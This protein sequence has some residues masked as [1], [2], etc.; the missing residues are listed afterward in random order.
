VNA[1]EIRRALACGQPQCKCARGMVHCPAHNDEKPSLAVSDKDGKVLIRCWAK[2]SQDAVI[3]ALQERG[4]WNQ[5]RPKTGRRKVRKA[6]WHV[7]GYVHEKTEYSDGSKDFKWKREDGTYGLNG[8]SLSS[9]PLYGADKLDGLTSDATIVVT[10]GEK[11]ADSLIK[12]EIP[13][14]GT[15]TGANET[16]C[17][18]SLK[19]LASYDVI[20][21]PDA[22]Q[23]G[24]DHM[25]RIAARLRESGHDNIRVIEWE[26][27][28]AKADAADFPGDNAAVRDL[29]NRARLY[30]PTPS[31]QLADLL[32][33]VRC[34]VRRYVAINDA[35]ADAIALWIAHTHAVDGAEAT[36]YIEITSA[37]KRSGKTR[38]LEVL[39]Q[40]AKDSWFTGRVSAAVLIRKLARGTATLLL[41]ESDAVFRGDKEYAEALRAVLN[42]GH[43][44]GGV[45]SLCVKSGA[46]FELRDFPVFGPKAIAGI[47]RLPETVA[48]RAI[49][50][51][52][53]RRAP[54]EHVE[55]FRRREA[56]QQ[57]QTSRTELERWSIGAV[58]N[59]SNARPDI[60]LELDDRAAD[61]WEP[62]LAIADLAG[63]AWPKRA[64]MAAL[65][66][67]AGDMREDD[68]LG[69]RLLLDV[70]TIFEEK[71]IDRIAIK[72]LVNALV[73]IEDAPWSDLKGRP[74]NPRGLGWRLKDFGIR[75]RTVRLEG[76]A[77]VRGY[78]RG[79]F[80]DAWLRYIPP[81]KPTHTDTTDTPNT[82]DVT[83]VTEVTVFPGMD[84]Q[85]FKC[86][87]CGSDDP[88]YAPDG[89]LFCLV[90]NPAL[91]QAPS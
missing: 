35:Q 90:C 30:E 41:D 82:N 15:V 31:A 49:T 12:R 1:V 16:P 8:T 66:L 42:S 87:K 37:E 18:D 62:L 61:G 57:A 20:L 50:I 86:Q 9:L 7:A 24:Q 69:V 64:R 80:E 6:E 36:P 52:L 34:F 70:R 19:A 4:L 13:A 81:E 84:A 54:G 83:V 39:A 22:D 14:V 65:E 75:A 17:P 48:D 59:L 51:S 3:A 27:A 63:G 10:E 55:R 77:V 23:A 38:L 74:L 33:E 5:P 2:C 45:A 28:P 91:M 21:W 43:R 46:D 53:K 32:N 72:A 85:A 79:W 78:Q 26:D 73:A 11:A 44:R 47:G 88:A 89:E 56:E 60:P 71:A 67:S 58:V 40:V 68:S 29:L 76:G 25:Q